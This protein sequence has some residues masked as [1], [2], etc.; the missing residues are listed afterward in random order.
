MKLCIC[1][2]KTIPTVTAG[3]RGQCTNMI[4]TIT[5]NKRVIDA[6]VV[7]FLRIVAFFGERDGWALKTC[8]GS[9]EYCTL[10]S[11]IY[12]S[13]SERAVLQLETMSVP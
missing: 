7:F 8:E 11:A 1:F 2:L 9:E 6:F 10:I 5:V 13:R 3:S 4:G 12:R